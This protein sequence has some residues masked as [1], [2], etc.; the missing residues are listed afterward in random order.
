MKNNFLLVSEVFYSMQGEGQ[1]MGIPAVFLR[2]GGCNILCKSKSWICDTIEVWQKSKKTYFNDVFNNR[3]MNALRN[4]AHLVL[5]GGEPLIHQDKIVDFLDWFMFKYGFFPIIEVETN[6]TIIPN[7]TFIRY[8]DYWNCSPKLSNSGVSKNKRINS[9]AI[10]MINRFDSSIFKFVMEKHSD[11]ID[12]LDDYGNIIDHRK[13]VLMPA[14]ETQEKLEITRPIVS[15]IAIDYY[16]RFSDRM[17]IT[18]WNQKT[19]V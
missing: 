8:I 14:G 3:Q 17:H 10:E 9:V 15:N 2:L 13:I 11:V 18:I 5:T 12:M 1:T 7:A 19:G 4:G 6:G 16:W